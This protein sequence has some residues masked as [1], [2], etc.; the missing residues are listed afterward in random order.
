MRVQ[1]YFCLLA[2]SHSKSFFS[3]DDEDSGRVASGSYWTYLGYES[4]NVIE[5][6]SYWE[7]YRA[8]LKGLRTS[9]RDVRGRSDGRD[10]V[11]AQKPDNIE[12]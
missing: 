4:E 12:L 2:F 6:Q 5:S 1:I 8:N 10:S 3:T 7:R 11:A 9:M